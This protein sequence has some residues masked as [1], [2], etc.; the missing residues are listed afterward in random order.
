MLSDIIN[1]GEVGSVM[2]VPAMVAAI[3]PGSTPARLPVINFI[4]SVFTEPKYMLTRS[5]GKKPIM[6]RKKEMKKEKYQEIFLEI[7]GR[8]ESR[9]QRKFMW[10]IMCIHI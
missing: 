6:R 3:T 2:L 9:E 1:V 8:L 5:T 4:K 10:K 7:T